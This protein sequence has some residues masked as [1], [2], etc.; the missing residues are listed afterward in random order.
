MRPNFW[1]IL[2]MST[3]GACVEYDLYQPPPAFGEDNPPAAENPVKTD[4]I[5]QLT[6]PSVD[7]LWVVDNSGSMGDNQQALA[8]NFPAF[9]NYFLGSGLDYHIGVVS[10]DMA[11]PDHRGKLREAAGVRF[12]TPDTNNP[13]NVFSNMAAIGANGA[14]TEKG[15]DAA[16]VALEIEKD[17]YNVDF[18]R[19]KEDSGVNVTVISDEDDYSTNITRG[20][21]IAF[22]NDLRP[23]DDLVT[24]NSIVNPPG[25]GFANQTGT[26]YLAVTDAVGGLKRDIGTGD[27]SSMLEDLGIQAA[28]LKSE[29]FLS[30]IPVVPTIKVWVEIGSSTRVFDVGEDYTYDQSRNSIRFSD[31]IPE[32]LAEVFIEYTVL[33]SVVN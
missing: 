25:G 10:T 5:V 13:V 24:F 14:D 29:Y 28:G 9:M 2:A 20:E 11:D 21:F 30:Q 16:F 4:R 18:L 15:R 22:L 23:E 31:Y 7:V 27:W 1:M 26:D 12:I 6:S 17:G 19:N 8:N 32:P 33:A 3:L